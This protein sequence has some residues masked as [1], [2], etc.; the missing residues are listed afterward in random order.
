MV[1][2]DLSTSQ[3]RAFKRILDAEETP[4]FQNSSGLDGL[5]RKVITHRGERYETSRLFVSDCPNLWSTY[6]FFGGLTALLGGLVVAATYGW[7]RF[8]S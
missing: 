4:I 8:R 3:Q 7:T 1:Y 6:Q 2:S 5:D